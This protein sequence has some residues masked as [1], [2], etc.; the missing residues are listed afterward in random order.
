MAYH[1]RVKSVR[2]RGKVSAEINNYLMPNSLCSLDKVVFN[3]E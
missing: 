1:K 2:L 3:Y